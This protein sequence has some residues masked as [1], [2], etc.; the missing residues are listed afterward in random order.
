MIISAPVRCLLVVPWLVLAA[1]PLARA[2]AAD[3]EATAR[4]F[5]A[6]ALAHPSI[7]LPSTR[8]RAQLAKM[9]SPE[10]M[11]LFEEA[12]ATEARCVR[13]A[14]KGE[15]PL[16]L[17]GNLFVGNYEGAS[18]VAYRKPQGTGDAVAIDADLVY[19]D[20]RFPKAHQHRTIAWKD[21]LELKRT[22]ARWLVQDVRFQDERS[23]A[24]TLKNYIA[25]GAKTCVVR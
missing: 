18:E 3:A 22:G 5:Y 15:K 13:A 4:M 23:L 1:A 2:Q 10:L 8:Q 16:I 24:G 11:H 20:A 17:E 25:D 14:P 12:S 6:W 9:L 21:R 7:S 19:I